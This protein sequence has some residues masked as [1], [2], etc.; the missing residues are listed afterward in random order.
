M[1]TSAKEIEDFEIVLSPSDATIVGDADEVRKRLKTRISGNDDEWPE[2]V[3]LWRGSDSEYIG[4][5]INRNVNTIYVVHF[6]VPGSDPRRDEAIRIVSLGIGS[7]PDL[8]SGREYVKQIWRG[9][10]P[11]D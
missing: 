10:K 9:L 3:Q 4:A 7:R 5:L 1:S 2:E 11:G 8:P 6:G